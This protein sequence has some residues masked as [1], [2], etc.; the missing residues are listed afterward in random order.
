[1]KTIKNKIMHLLNNK[2][3]LYEFPIQ[4]IT[5]SLHNLYGITSVSLLNGNL[6]NDIK[7]KLYKIILGEKIQHDVKIKDALA[8]GISYYEEPEGIIYG[9]DN[10]IVFEYAYY[11]DFIYGALRYS[12]KR[13][14]KK[15]QNHI[16]RNTE[17]Y[18][19]SHIYK[20]DDDTINKFKL[21]GVDITADI[22][23][24]LV[25]SNRLQLLY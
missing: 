8:I 11:I 22:I 6:N 7:T 18:M 2:K 25:D 13:F 21:L 16:G 15:L 9:I 24:E 19:L 1:M 10:N 3:Q 14:D 5:S 17:I 20:L 23:E 12:K 4:N